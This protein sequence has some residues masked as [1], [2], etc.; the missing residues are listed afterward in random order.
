VQKLN[1]AKQTEF[2]T[3]RLVEKFSFNFPLMEWVYEVDERE[4]GFDD[5]ALDEEWIIVMTLDG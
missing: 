4:I 5:A 1:L 3:V 2:Q